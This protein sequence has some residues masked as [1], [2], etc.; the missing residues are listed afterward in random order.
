MAECKDR[1]NFYPTVLDDLKAKAKKLGL[2]NMFL[3]KTHFK[4]GAG[5]TNLEYGLIAGILGKSSLASSAVNCA[6][7][8]TGNMEVLA[9]Y[10]TEQQKKQWLEPLLNAE[11]RSAF[12]M[13]ERKVASSDAKNIS[14]TMERVGD[15]YVLNGSVRHMFLLSFGKSNSK[16]NGGVVVPEIQDARFMLYSPSPIQKRK[17]FTNSIQLFLF[18]LVGLV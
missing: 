10:G 13:T 9:R 2:W 11:I 12:L 17:V 3:S 18:Q 5:F 15:E 7:P 6:A 14:M 1:W 16:R 8:D 4:E